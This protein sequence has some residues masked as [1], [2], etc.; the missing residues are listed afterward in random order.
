MTLD[1]KTIERSGVM[2]GG[3][4]PRQGLIRV[5]GKPNNLSVA[6]IMNLKNER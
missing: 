2:S 4:R 3:G 6:D 5:Q 1:G